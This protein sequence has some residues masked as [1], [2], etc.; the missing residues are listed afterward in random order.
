MTY[1]AILRPRGQKGHSVTHLR[2]KM[3]HMLSNGWV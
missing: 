2:P 3:V 1:F